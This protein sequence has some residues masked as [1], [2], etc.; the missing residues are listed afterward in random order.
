MKQLLIDLR[1]PRAADPTRLYT[2][3]NGLCIISI[4]GDDFLIRTCK[5][6]PIAS[7]TFIDL[8]RSIDFI[9]SY[10]L[11]N[12]RIVNLMDS[13]IVHW[14]MGYMRM[15]WNAKWQICTNWRW[16]ACDRMRKE[17][18]RAVGH[19]CVHSGWSC[20]NSHLH[21]FVYLPSFAFYRR[22]IISPHSMNGGMRA[23]SIYMCMAV[24]GALTLCAQRLDHELY[25][26]RLNHNSQ[27]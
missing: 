14:T 17:P 5:F 16:S 3:S 8:S 20:L 11:S 1:H 25:C 6:S 23:S 9:I 27:Q 19:W 22:L 21:K 26:F 12:V 2:W 7:C 10:C 24:Y 15:N 13:L 4:G 18:R